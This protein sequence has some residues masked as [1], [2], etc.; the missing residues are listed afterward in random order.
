MTATE[1]LGKIRVFLRKNGWV[2]LDETDPKS[3][4]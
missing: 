1:W 4:G 2:P 3:A